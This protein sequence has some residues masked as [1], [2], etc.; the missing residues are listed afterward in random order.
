MLYTRFWYRARCFLS[1]AST[2]G[3]F[4]EH[5]NSFCFNWKPALQLNDNKRDKKLLQRWKKTFMLWKHNG[6]STLNCNLEE[7]TA[8]CSLFWL[9][10]CSFFTESSSKKMMK[11]SCC[12]KTCNFIEALSGAETSSYRW[13]QM[14]ISLM[15]KEFLQ[16]SIKSQ[17]HIFQDALCQPSSC[18][19]RLRMRLF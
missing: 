3:Y 13:L 4:I 9:D 18:Y 7:W 16:V 2:G 12:S 1:L 15:W 8:M 17:F 6:L 10:Q 14:L 19:I 5:C 11:L